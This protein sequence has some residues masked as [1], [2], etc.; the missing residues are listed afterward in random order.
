MSGNDLKQYSNYIRYSFPDDDSLTIFGKEKW[1]QDDMN[2]IED[3]LIKEH[4]IKG[5]LCVKFH[6][7]VLFDNNLIEFIDKE[8]EKICL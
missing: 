2:E 1:S 5:H 7:N 8:L 4:D 6:P 3:R